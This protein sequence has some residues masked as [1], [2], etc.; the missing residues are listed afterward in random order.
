MEEHAQKKHREKWEHVD[1]RVRGSFAKAATRKE[2]YVAGTI[3][4]GESI[5]LIG[6][7]N[8][9]TDFPTH[10]TEESWEHVAPRGKSK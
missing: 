1:A 8:K 4:R 7:N 6:K 10:G 3:S 5:K 9:C 2:N